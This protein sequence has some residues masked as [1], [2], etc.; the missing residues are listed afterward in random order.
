MS[1][2][3]RLDGTPGEDTSTD[4]TTGYRC[5]EADFV[6]A[7]TEVCKECDFL[8]AANLAAQAVAQYRDTG[9]IDEDLLNQLERAI[10]E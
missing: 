7:M 8:A 9:K 4:Q 2:I 5:P 3:V 10:E 6:A 1:K